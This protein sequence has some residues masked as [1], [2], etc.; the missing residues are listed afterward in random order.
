MSALV[1]ST[2]SLTPLPPRGSITNWAGNQTF[3]PAHIHHPRSVA[4]LQALV[5]S[6]THIHAAGTCHSFNTSTATPHDLV[7]LDAL[8]AP[9]SLDAVAG[10][11]TVSAATTYGALVKFLAPTA[12][13]VPNLASLP[14]ISI[15]GSIA[16]ATHGS[17]V[18]NGNLASWVVGLELV[19]AD[20]VLHCLTRASVDWEGYP[21]HLGALGVVT[22]V[23]LE[24]VPA[25]TVRQDLYEGLS[26]GSAT[27]HFDAIMSAGYSV[28][29]FT[30]W[31][32]DA[33]FE[34]VW[35]KSSVRSGEE[36]V[37]VAMPSEWYGA[38]LATTA[39]H[40]IPG[41]SGEECTVQ[42]GVAGP[43]YD[44]LAHFRMEF[45]PSAG[46]ELQSEYFVARADAP[47]ALAAVAILRSRISP[48]LHISE[49][50][51]IA[52]DALWMSTA[53]GR[54]STS[55]H[56]TWKAMDKEVGGD[57]DSLTWKAKEVLGGWGERCLAGRE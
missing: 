47:A 29:L 24:L 10:T 33:A 16:S 37:A 4:E 49:I 13:S 38:R 53:Y 54:D 45:C 12:W 19:A 26:F 22:R 9:P 40:P 39:L 15:G 44:R 31:G 7:L 20:G 17:G 11:V 8:E 52:E 34:Q 6:C 46:A 28:S 55:I 36:A 27:A 21:V 18:G 42:L 32:P 14:H 41:V 23:T 5:A 30:T 25:F 3:T 2:S 48:L 35:R 50:R 43:S 56:F 51:C 57:G 1:G